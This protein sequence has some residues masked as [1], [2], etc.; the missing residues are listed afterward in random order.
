MIHSAYPQT[1]KMHHPRN[2]LAQ[3][4]AN[5]SFPLQRYKPT[6]R[7]PWSVKKGEFNYLPLCS[8]FFLFLRDD[9]LTI[10]QFYP[11]DIPTWQPRVKN[12]MRLTDPL[13]SFSLPLHLSPTRPRPPSMPALPRRRPPMAPPRGRVEV[14]VEDNEG[15]E[16]EEHR[17][18]GRTHWNGSGYVA[19]MRYTAFATS[20]QRIWGGRRCRRGGGQRR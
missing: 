14:G 7:D 10:C 3:G 4:C 5:F 6:V 20:H 1:S 2:F 8:Y 19:R 11:R 16:K 13:V 15:D 12:D 18:H 9:F 17:H